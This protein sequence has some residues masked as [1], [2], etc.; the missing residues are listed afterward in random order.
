MKR[1]DAERIV[2]EYLD[3]HWRH[4]TEVE[5]M[6]DRTIEREYG[7]IFLYQSKK[8]LETNNLRDMLIGNAPILVKHL[9]ETVLFPTSLRVEESIRRYEAGEALSPQRK[10]R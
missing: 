6:H 8:Y 4:I 9:G 5:I 2:Q 10:P 7:W 3:S 1:E